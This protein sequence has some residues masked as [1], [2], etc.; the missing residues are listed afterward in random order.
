MGKLFGKC[1]NRA[2][3]PQIRL[4]VEL[5]GP[6]VE[7]VL[8]TCLLSQRGDDEEVADDAREGETHLDEH[9]GHALRRGLHRSSSSQIRTILQLEGSSSDAII[10]FTSSAFNIRVF[11][12]SCLLLTPYRE[13]IVLLSQ[14]GRKKCFASTFLLQFSPCKHIVFSPDIGS[15]ELS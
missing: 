7:N 12:T 5:C 11:F 4:N 13:P 1:L 10:R 9:Q 14:T 6:G 8:F 3:E 2:Q 15:C